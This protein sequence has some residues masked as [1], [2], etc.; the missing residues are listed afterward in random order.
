M[1]SLS[2]LNR[3][4][5]WLLDYAYTVVMTLYQDHQPTAKYSMV[6]NACHEEIIQWCFPEVMSCAH[7]SSLNNRGNQM[8]AMAWLALEADHPELILALARHSRLVTMGEIREQKASSG[9]ASTA[10]KVEQEALLLRQF[11]AAA[12]APGYWETPPSSSTEVTVP[13]RLATQ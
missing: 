13:T 12:G 7:G 1:A 2:T 10:G 6:A 11:G 8:E 4:G 3:L 5:A 9:T